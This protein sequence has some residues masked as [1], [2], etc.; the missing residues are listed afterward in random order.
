METAGVMMADLLASAIATAP[1][2]E[3]QRDILARRC[4]GNG[5]R[6]ETLTQVAAGYGLSRERIRQIEAKAWSR[7]RARA[8]RA[9]RAGDE[10]HPCASLVDNVGQSIRPD[11]DGVAE[12]ALTFAREHLPAWPE[13]ERTFRVVLF[14]A[15]LGRE[16]SS[17]LAAEAEKL[18]RTEREAAVL[19]ARTERSDRLAKFIKTSVYW[20]PQTR[21]YAE[22]VVTGRKRLVEGSSPESLT[23]WSEKMGRHVVYESQLELRFYLR[24]EGSR[25]VSWYQEQPFEIP[26]RVGPAA[27]HYYPDVAFGLRDGRVVV[28]EIKPRYQWALNENWIKWSALRQFCAD[29]GFGFVIADGSRSLRAMMRYP[30]PPEFKQD[31]LRAVAASQLRWQD[32]A[33]IQER[34]SATWADFIALVLQERLIWHLP[35]LLVKV[36]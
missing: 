20:P 9:K 18:G 8:R 22:P 27:R 36:S 3:R 4:G 25:E 24:L 31:V 17:T 26:F 16:L 35:F 21:T 19:E 7:I 11:E 33:P 5:G 6:P 29:R 28:V 12:R 32:Y 14:L 30:V 1:L 10:R 34:H 23:F 2:S 13:I 15:G